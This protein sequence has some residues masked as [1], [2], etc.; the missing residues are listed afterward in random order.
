M[1]GSVVWKLVTYIW[2][3][4]LSFSGSNSPESV[5]CW[6][7]LHQS[8]RG[9]IP[10]H[11]KHHSNRYEILKSSHFNP[12][13]VLTTNFFNT[14][15]LGRSRCPFAIRTLVTDR[16]S[17]CRFSWNF[18]LETFTKKKKL[19]CNVNF[20]LD[21]VAPTITLHKELSDVLQALRGQLARYLTQQNKKKKKKKT[22]TKFL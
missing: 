9:N 10:K 21:R 22:R 5:N 1:S 11:L 8:T 19:S 3:V 7:W 13:R 2:N 4:Q 18:I 20:H 14:Q 15:S 17:L 12:P 16:G 6:D